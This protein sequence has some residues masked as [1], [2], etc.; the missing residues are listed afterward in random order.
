MLAW[1]L[2]HEAISLTSVPRA[3][4]L[5]ET[6]RAR[7]YLL[8]AQAKPRAPAG[9]GLSSVPISANP[10]YLSATSRGKLTLW[11]SSTWVSF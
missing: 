3:H 6:P 4:L 1:L 9:P 10:P 7:V 11:L 2:C 5:R 8:T